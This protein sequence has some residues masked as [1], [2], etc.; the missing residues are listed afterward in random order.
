MA[1]TDTKEIKSLLA[2]IGELQ[3]C[4]ASLRKSGLS[5]IFYDVKV[6]EDATV[7]DE[8]TAC[9]VHQGHEEQPQEQ[10]G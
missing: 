10:F 1:T 3:P 2:D 9:E 8:A 4:A 7:Y 5:L 6:W